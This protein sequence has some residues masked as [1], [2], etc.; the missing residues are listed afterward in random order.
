MK[1]MMAGTGYV[2][3]VSGTCFA[4]SGNDV[5]CVDNQTEKVE[6]LNRGEIPI[7][8]TGLQELVLKNTDE[9][10]LSFT[11]D[12]E[13]SAAWA[14]VIFIAVGTPASEDGA[15]D[16]SYVYNVA[17]EIG[18]A[19]GD[20]YTIVVNKST[21]PIGTAE[22]VASLIKEQTPEAN[23]DVCSVP[24]FLREGSAVHD[25]F[26]PDRTV[27]GAPTEKA[28]Q[29]LRDLHEPF[30]NNFVITD[31][32]SAEMIKYASNA[33]LATKISFINEIANICDAYEADVNAVAT[34]MGLDHR[35]GPKFL[36][37]GIGYGGSCF[38]KDIRALIHMA[39]TYDYEPRVLRA[40]EEVNEQQGMRII[41]HLDQIYEN[42]LSDRT[43]AV[44]GLAFKPN[45]NDMRDAPSI[46]IIRE[47][48][49]RGAR[50]KAYDPIVGEEGK[51]IISDEIELSGSSFE[52]M[53]DADVLVIVTEWPEFKDL[54][55]SEMK[56][57]LNAPIVIDGRNVFDPKEMKKH[58]FIYRGIGR[59]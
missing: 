52:A 24:E 41:E 3:L 39:E 42:D 57:R 6:M 16:L 13:A 56:D 25:T 11:T 50:V 45:T 12:M 14:D 21:V 28:C 8:E 1:I 26:H 23:V 40:V 46:K 54:S 17:K 5:I 48:L 30:A 4:E 59:K 43:V 35:I 27:I 7:Y 38:P 53:E 51:A 29:K 10:R 2:G 32:R 36:N 34:G 18:S 19:I 15:A 33:F 49:R 44:F 9:G 20:S 55:L 37:P 31:V 47:L 58:G 22:K